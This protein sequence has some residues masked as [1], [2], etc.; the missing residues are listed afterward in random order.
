M[1]KAGRYYRWLVIG[2]VL[3]LFA[4]LGLG[5]FAPG[6]QRSR[7]RKVD[8]D[9]NG[10]FKTVL[11]M[12]EVDCGRF[13]T[14]KEGL[15]PLVSSP[16]NVEHWHG[17]YFDPPAVPEDPWGHEYVYRFPGV[18]NPNGY[19]L[20]SLGPDGV[21]KTGGNDRDDIGNWEKPVPSGT[22][23]DMEKM[24]EMAYA[25]LLFIPILFG[26]RVVAGIISSRVHKVAMEN[27]WADWV[28]FAIAVITII[29]VF[30]PKVAERAY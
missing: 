30:M 22:I 3:L 21:S 19:D 8:L 14:T 13:P 4:V 18:H 17:P 5:A 12:F 23:R 16:T 24:F 27:R 7:T 25:L 1:Q 28:W 29:I 6:D 26:V 9:I 15:R 11:D 2:Q 20:Y 10:G